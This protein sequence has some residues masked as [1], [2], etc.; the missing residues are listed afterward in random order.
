MTAQELG[1]GAHGVHAPGAIR[2]ALAHAQRE[3]RRG[4][5]G[6]ILPGELCAA[7]S[8]AQSRCGHVQRGFKH[9]LS[10]E[11]YRI[12]GAEQRVA[13]LQSHAG[14]VFVGLA[15]GKIIE[16]SG[17][18]MRADAAAMLA[19]F[20][21]IYLAVAHCGAGIGAHG[22]CAP[23]RVIDDKVQSIGLSALSGYLAARHLA[24]ALILIKLQPGREYLVAGEF[25]KLF[26]GH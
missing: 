11:N 3:R 7:L 10:N 15:A 6:V 17:H 20:L 12:V 4:N 13:R 19:I 21:L 25:A 22:N 8:R 1:H 14:E 26:A 5:G 24:H 16:Y 23:R 2:A 18:H 9:E